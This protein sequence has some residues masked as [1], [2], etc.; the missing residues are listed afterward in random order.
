MVVYLIRSLA[1]EYPELE[2]HIGV[3]CSAITYVG[4]TF[5]HLEWAFGLPRGSP[6]KE[7]IDTLL[8]RYREIGYLDELWNKYAATGTGTCNKKL[9]MTLKLDN[10][11]GL[12]YALV[13]GV[14]VA[15]GSFVVEFVVVARNRPD[16]VNNQSEPT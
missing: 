11:I 9:E 12:F 5:Q 16:Q 10:L 1:G 6:Y 2:Y 14:G 3:G 8:L 13:C 15:L 4:H 7:L